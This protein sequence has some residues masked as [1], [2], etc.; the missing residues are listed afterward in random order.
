[1]HPLIAVLGPTGSGKSAL[2][3]ALAIEFAGEIVNCDSV[4]VHSGLD[5][6]S[7]KTPLDQRQ[8]I[9]HHMLDVIP[10]Q[11]ELTA[12]AYARAARVVLDRLRE[13]G[14]LPILVGG[15]GFYVRAVLDGLSPAP[16]RDPDLRSRLARLEV[17]RPGSL[18]RF[19]TRY[20]PIAAGRI[21]PNDLQKLTRAVEMTI[22]AGRAASEIQ[23]GERMALTDFRVLKLGL[24]PRREDLRRQIDARTVR[25]FANGLIEETR[26]L[27]DAGCPPSAKALQS[28]GYRQA[29]KLLSGEITAA[30]AVAECQLKTRQ[31]AKR[32]MTWFRR[33]AAIHWLSGFGTDTSVQQ[34]AIEIVRHWLLKQ[35]S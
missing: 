2:G 8:A 29:V 11:G 16:E 18:Y 6:G 9:P 5:I 28:L 24:A 13:R 20:D 12:G 30:A 22:S 35:G 26:A 15:T 4:Q 1:M 33:D 10:P 3:L 17:R 27:L 23:S 21:H 34:N 7:A 25:M 14:I 32:Q 31:Y 19:L